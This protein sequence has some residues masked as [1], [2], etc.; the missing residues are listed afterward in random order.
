MTLWEWLVE[1]IRRRQPVLQPAPVR[2]RERIVE[3][4]RRRG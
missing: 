1:S 2:V 4:P 3:R